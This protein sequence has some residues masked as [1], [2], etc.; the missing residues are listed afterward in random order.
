M[1]Q[2]TEDFVNQGIQ[3][4]NLDYDEFVQ[5]DEN[6]APEIVAQASQIYNKELSKYETIIADQ[7][8]VAQTYLNMRR[9]Y[10]NLQV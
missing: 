10:A 3:Q 9:G 1:T 6:Q 4:T 2:S 8:K 5:A 7:A